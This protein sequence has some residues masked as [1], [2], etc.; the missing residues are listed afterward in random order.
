MIFKR[1]D[2]STCGR[3]ERLYYR[4]QVYAVLVKLVSLRARELPVLWNC[5]YYYASVREERF[6]F[7]TV[8]SEEKTNTKHCL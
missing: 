8:A 1:S 3:A 2:T 7:I 5:L 4:C 6:N